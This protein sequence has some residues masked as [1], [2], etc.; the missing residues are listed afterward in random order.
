MHALTGFLVFVLL[1]SS[2]ALLL[3]G[4]ALH[5]ACLFV[6]SVVAFWVAA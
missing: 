3:E 4:Y 2:A 6:A 5:A 1:G